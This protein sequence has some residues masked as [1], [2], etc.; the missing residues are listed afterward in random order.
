M[1]EFDR[2]AAT[3]D[4][5][6][7][8]VARAERVAEAIRELVDDL[9]DRSALEV[10]C[11][12]GLLGFALRPHVARITL[13]DTSPGMLEVLRGKIADAG[14]QGMEALQ[15]DFTQGP[16]PEARYGLVCSLM[17][18]HHIPDTEGALRRFHDI[19]EPGGLLCMADLDREDG[20]FHGAG[21][22]VHLGF[23]R[24]ALRAQLQRAG[25]QDIRFRTP[26][27]IARETG[28]G[29]RQY[30]VFLVAARRPE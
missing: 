30:P 12:T 28:Q 8:K 10:G 17:V 27:V 16:L 26:F 9:A 11:G 23:D 15:H 19:L 24:E 18:L 14:F 25:F 22:D 13:A 29:P 4:Q 20:S 6:A 5:D 7:A 21:V 1:S 3:W 2:K